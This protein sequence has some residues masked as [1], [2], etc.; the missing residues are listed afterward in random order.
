MKKT[1]LIVMALLMCLTCL[2]ELPAYTYTGTN[3]IEAAVAE[4]SA[5][6]GAN[7][8][9]EA[10]NVTIPAP[11]ILKVKMADN[12]HA[13]VY[14]NFWH[15]NY[16]LRGDVL[17]CVSGGAAPGVMELEKA[18]NGWKVVS[19]KIAGD[20]SD[21]AKDIARFSTGD[22]E[23][24]KLYAASGDVY[25]DPLLSAR[26]NS[27]R[28]YVKANGLKIRAYQDEYWPEIPIN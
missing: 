24:E 1:F 12:G 8:L 9:Q 21:Y 6:F 26:T 25:S 17:L 27:V 4:Y 3:K 5:G 18:E 14:G 28:E 16:T 10:V 13:N 15:F 22:R 20:G 2:A 7:Y 19:C 11:V 23:L